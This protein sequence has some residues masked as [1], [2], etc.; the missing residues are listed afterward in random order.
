MKWFKHLSGSLNNSVIFESIETFGSD[1][2]LVFFGTLEIMADE[3]DI[4]NPGV[5]RISIKKLTKNLQLSRQKITRILSFFDQKAKENPTEKRAFFAEI[6]KTHVVINCPKLKDLCDEWTAKQISKVGS[7]SGATPELL[8]PK[9]EEVE[10]N[11]PL[12]P[13]PQTMEYP[14]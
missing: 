12:P 3:F 4:Q 7:K 9:E 8:P 5:S 2:Y 6:E 11:T 10:N 14:E 1:A 13:L